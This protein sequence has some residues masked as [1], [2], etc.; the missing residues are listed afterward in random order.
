MEDT[1]EYKQ[2]LI[3]GVKIFINGNDTILCI[4]DKNRNLVHLN[5]ETSSIEK[6][7]KLM[8][9]YKKRIESYLKR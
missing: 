3:N 7:K 1:I 2:E 8:S 4:P 9:E 6:S 5:V